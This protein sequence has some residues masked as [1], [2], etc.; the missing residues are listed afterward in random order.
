MVPGSYP[1]YLGGSASSSSS[2]GV[3]STTLCS[4]ITAMSLAS[5]QGMQISAPRAVRA[6]R[7]P[8]PLAAGHF[9]TMQQWSG[10]RRRTTAASRSQACAH[11]AVPRPAPPFGSLAARTS[12]LTYTLPSTPSILSFPPLLS[13]KSPHVAQHRARSCRHSPPSARRRTQEGPVL[14]TDG[15]APSRAEAASRGRG[16]A[17]LRK[18]PGSSPPFRHRAGADGDMT[19]SPCAP[20]KISQKCVIIMTS[21]ASIGVG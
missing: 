10:R 8:S 13:P 5:T 7:L 9:C 2:H 4:A 14:R 19:R 12:A 20:A 3:W 18:R 11:S 21:T 16:A 17:P 6:L 1:I 15:R